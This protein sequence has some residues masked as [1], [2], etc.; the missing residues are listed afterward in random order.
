MS[1]DQK[2]KEMLPEDNI[3]T[4]S[5]GSTLEVK[6]LSWGKEI[7]VCK[8]VSK[9]FGETELLSAFNSIASSERRR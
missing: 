3:Y 5:D 1:E 9:F 6:P 2:V 8:I 4:L 7:K